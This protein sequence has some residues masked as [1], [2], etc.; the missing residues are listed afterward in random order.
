MFKSSSGGLDCVEG[1][2]AGL[3][4]SV[5]LPVCCSVCCSVCLP[6]GTSACRHEGK[7]AAVALCAPPLVPV[8]VFRLLMLV[9]GASGT[10]TN[11]CNLLPGCS[12][13]WISQLYGEFMV[14]T[15]QVCS[16]RKSCFVQHCLR[17]TE[18]TRQ[19][20]LAWPTCSPHVTS[21]AAAA[22]CGPL[23]L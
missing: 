11:R 15:V 2:V 17:S 3:H 18:H 8:C 19:R 10:L 23:P 7:P 12:L 21:A 6:I 20:V 22:A 14:A 13:A 16:G 5:Y 1:F 9:T 4:V